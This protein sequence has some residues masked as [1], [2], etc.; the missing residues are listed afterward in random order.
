MLADDLS[1]Y[2]ISLRKTDE[3]TQMSRDFAPRLLSKSDVVFNLCSTYLP[4]D[5][6]RWDSV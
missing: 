2:L 5:T 6:G 1:Q 4:A 3:K